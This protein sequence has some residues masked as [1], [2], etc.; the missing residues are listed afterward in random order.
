MAT[1]LQQLKPYGFTVTIDD[2][3]TGYSSLSYLHQLP[4]DALKID[5]SFV[6]AMEAN[7]RNS[8]IVETI[9]T[10]SNRLGLAAI[11]EGVETQAQFEHLQNLGCELA[12]GYWLAKPLPAAI[13][14]TLL[15]PTP[16]STSCPH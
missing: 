10:L 2:F 15:A 7:H 9:I 8:D 3:G 13:A 11:A 1:I 16:A 12:Q 5:R 6:M 14:E 4:V